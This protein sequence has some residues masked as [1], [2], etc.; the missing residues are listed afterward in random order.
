MR[1]TIEHQAAD[2]RFD[3]IAQLEFFEDFFHRAFDDGITYAQLRSISLFIGSGLSHKRWHS[4]FASRRRSR[5]LMSAS[6]TRPSSEKDLPHD[7]ERVAIPAQTGN[8]CWNDKFC[9]C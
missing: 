2:R 3:A 7:R 9:P 8:R 5:S 6:S 4:L 1:A